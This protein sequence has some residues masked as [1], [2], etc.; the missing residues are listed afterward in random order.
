MAASRIPL[1]DPGRFQ[2]NAGG[3]F[4]SSLGSSAWMIVTSCL[5]LLNSQPM[6]ATVPAIAFAIVATASLLLWSRRDRIYP[7]SAMMALL[8]LLAIA[9]PLVWIVVQ[10]YGSPSALAAMNWS[11]SRWPTILVVAIVPALMIWFLLLERLGANKD[12]T[13]KRDSNVVA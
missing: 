9:L 2:W 4:G 11:E 12:D 6:L 7:F 10:S 3:W 13:T 1:V 5:L 8:G